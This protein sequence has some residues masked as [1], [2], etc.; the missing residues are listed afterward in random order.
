M[1]NTMIET[2]KDVKRKV[3]AMLDERRAQSNGNRSIFSPSEYWADFCSFFDYMLGLSEESFAKLRLHTYHLTGDNYQAY[4]LGD[5]EHFR[6]ALGVDALT[7]GIPAKYILNEPEGGIGFRFPG[8]RFVSGDILR[9]Q[10]AVNALFKSGVFSELENNGRRNV[11]LEIGAG[12]GGLAHHLSAILGN[13]TAVI[14]DLPETLLYSASYLSL[15]NPTKRIYFYEPENFEEF[16]HSDA[17]NSTDFI[18]LPNY[19]LDRLRHLR[20]DLAVNVA[21]FQEMRTG[22]VQ[23]YLD[24]IRETCRG[25]LYSCNQDRQPRNLELTNLSELLRERFEAVEILPVQK[26]PKR[27]V[28]NSIKR[29][30]RTLATMTGFTEKSESV[31][32]PP[33]REFI[34]KPTGHFLA[35]R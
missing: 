25:V 29:G 12:Y 23:T 19:K 21:S 4:Y 28:K 22:Q 27:S 15:L 11:V 2:I 5:A 3:K 13:A 6:T 24:F 7:E 17:V 31:T 20:F 18:L 32:I 10:R 14:V 34:C 30:I 1:D 33:Y 26:L 9:F 35:R 16:I 8:G